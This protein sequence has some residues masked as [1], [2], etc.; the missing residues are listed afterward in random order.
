MSK[1]EKPQFKFT[2]IDNMTEERKTVLGDVQRTVEHLLRFE[3]YVN[4]DLFIY[5]FG[6]EKGWRY[7]YLFANDCKRSVLRL[8]Q[9]MDSRE[10][11]ALLTEA[12][13]PE[14]ALGR[15]GSAPN[16]NPIYAYC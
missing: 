3:Y 7:A 14:G 16:S 6:E 2:P 15:G 5:L 1:Q 8:M 4:L 9:Q 12:I 11:L 13:I 10:D